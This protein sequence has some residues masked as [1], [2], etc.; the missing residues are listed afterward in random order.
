VGQV[1]SGL[2]ADIQLP[3]ELR[4][5]DALLGG[6]NQMDRQKR[7]G[8]RLMGVVKDGASL[9]IAPRD[10]PVA[11]SVLNRN[12]PHEDRRNRHDKGRHE[13]NRLVTGDGSSDSRGQ[14]AAGTTLCGYP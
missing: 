4:G 12:Y 9:R 8:Q 7:I 13:S 6:A 2:I 5:T 3:F 1:P 14:D 11:V 10:L